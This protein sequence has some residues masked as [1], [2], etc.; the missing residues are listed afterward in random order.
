M[1]GGIEGSS[2]ARLGYS[3]VRDDLEDEGLNSCVESLIRRLRLEPGRDAP[4]DVRER[5]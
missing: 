4:D 5:E 2:S 1:R 3:L